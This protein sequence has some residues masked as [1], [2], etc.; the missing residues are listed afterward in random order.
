MSAEG[1]RRVIRAVW[2]PF[3][4]IALLAL[5]A[6]LVK[7]NGDLVVERTATLMA[8]NLVIAIALYLFSGNSGVLSFGH[9]AFVGLGAYICA[10]LTIP[11]ALKE[12]LFPEMPGFLHWILAVHLGLI[13]AALIAGLAAALLA[14]VAAPALMRLSGLAA[15]IGT[16]ALLV[17]VYT[18]LLNWEQ[19]TRGSN[20]M[21]GVPAD[22]TLW[23]A[24]AASMVAIVVA[25]AYQRSRWGLKLRASREDE[26]AA[27]SL[28]VTVPT[29]RGFAWI[30][31]AF[32]AGA[33]GAFYSHFITTFTPEVFYLEATFVILVMVVVGG[34][35]SLTGA[36]VGV[37]LISAV[38]FELGRLQNGDLIGGVT[39][40]AGTVEVVV[41]VILLLIL[42]VRPD[43]LSRGREVPLPRRWRRS[44]GT[45]PVL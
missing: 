22:L 8:V 18:V 21:I 40:P 45:P 9:L 10:L 28:G 4:L 29:T 16:L 42:V 19:V 39:L 44:G 15:G 34:I 6:V 7:L 37:V 5:G 26:V 41:A 11:P 38:Q 3:V 31:S 24:L 43:G 2:V 33:A 25:W 17:I 30:L 27:R 1:R 12:S 35:G 14:L 32:L 36:V 13:P 23:G 20:T